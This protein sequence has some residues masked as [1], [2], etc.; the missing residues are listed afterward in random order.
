M[1]KAIK[2]LCRPDI[3]YQ[4]HIAN[5]TPRKTVVVFH[6][7]AS[8]RKPHFALST[9]QAKQ[10]IAY[11]RI[12]DMTVRASRET[13]EIMRRDKN[14][15]GVQFHFGPK[16]KVL[17]EY[18][19]QHR[20]ITVDQFKR[21]AEISRRTASNTLILL[22]LANVISITPQTKQDVFTLA[23]SAAR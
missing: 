5:I 13:L 18:L 4:C 1:D 15:N 6:I 7:A 14:R 23:S 10:G 8:R 11:I 16:E 19:D 20:F 17:M 3:K 2:S 21:A 12:L 22:V 9:P